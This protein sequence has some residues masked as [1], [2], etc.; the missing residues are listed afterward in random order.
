MSDDPA[1]KKPSKTAKRKPSGKPFEA[2]APSANPNGRPKGSRNKSTLLLEAM[3]DDVGQKVIKAVIDMA[4]EGDV[5]LLKWIADR[6]VPARK[7]R[8]VEINLGTV[9]TAADALRASQVVVQAVAAGALTPSEGEQLSKALQTHIA[10]HT[11]VELES[12]LDSLEQ[13]HGVG[14]LHS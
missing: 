11:T 14:A 3:L 6:L 2:G 13:A 12:Q 8:Y 1:V 10:L 5:T 9:H 7:D 4:L